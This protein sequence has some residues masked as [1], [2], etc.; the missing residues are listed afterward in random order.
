MTARMAAVS[1][2]RCTLNALR[3][4]TRDLPMVAFCVFLILLYC[5]ILV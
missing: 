5:H 1:S 2:K 3:G 4:A